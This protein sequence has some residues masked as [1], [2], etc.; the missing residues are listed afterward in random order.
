VLVRR[1]LFPQ[2]TQCSLLNPTTIRKMTCYS[3]NV[4]RTRVVYLLYY[5]PH[6]DRHSRYFSFHS[7]ALLPRETAD[8]PSNLTQSGGRL[9]QVVTLLFISDT[10]LFQP[11]ISERK[12]EF[13]FLSINIARSKG[14]YHNRSFRIYSEKRIAP[15]EVNGLS[16]ETT[17]AGHTFA[18]T[19][20]GRS[21]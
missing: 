10:F 3:K 20:M 1:H 4:K 5:R 12:Q 21:G 18:Q 7:H 11:A 9:M 2:C 8:T 14:G 16:R 6:D 13:F 19:V 17:S 15:I